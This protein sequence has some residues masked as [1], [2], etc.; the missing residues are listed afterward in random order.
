MKNHRRKSSVTT[1]SGL[2]LDKNLWHFILFFCPC[3]FVAYPLWLC[4][5]ALT[6]EFNIAMSSLASTH[7]LSVANDIHNPTS[8]DE[9]YGE[10]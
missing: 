7:V 1:Y 8:D 9:L 4:F 2:G 5:V 3:S 10:I 6:F